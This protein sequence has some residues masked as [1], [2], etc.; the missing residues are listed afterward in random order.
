MI[1]ER[2]SSA[3]KQTIAS[4]ASLRQKHSTPTTRYAEEQLALPTRRLSEFVVVVVGCRCW[5]SFSRPIFR[6]VYN[7]LS[8]L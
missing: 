4:A 7:L 1:A 3:D 6:R 2:Q 8:L 5:A